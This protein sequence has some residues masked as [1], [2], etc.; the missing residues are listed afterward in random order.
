[1][2]RLGCLMSAM[3]VMHQADW[4]EGKRCQTRVD[5][6]L[7]VSRQAAISSASEVTANVAPLS[8][9]KIGR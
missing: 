6:F 7:T 5:L 1:M 4:S 2:C 3:G 8:A 9:S